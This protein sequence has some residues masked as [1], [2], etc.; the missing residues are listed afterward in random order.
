MR[1]SLIL[2]TAFIAIAGGLIAIGTAHAEDPTILGSP[3]IQVNPLIGNGRIVLTLQNESQKPLA[4][5]LSAGAL[6]QTGGSKISDAAITFGAETDQGPGDL[7]Y[8]FTIP[9]QSTFKVQAI[10]EKE[11]DPGQFEA[12]LKNQAA[13]IGK[14]KVAFFPVNVKIDSATPDKLDLSLVGSVWTAIY[15]KNSD[16]AAYNL[17][18]RLIVGAREIAKNDFSIPPNGTAMLEFTPSIPVDWWNPQ[19]YLARFQDLFKPQPHDGDVLLLY[20]GQPGRTTDLGIPIKKFPVTASLNFFGPA[21]QGVLSYL[22]L[23]AILTLGGVTSLVLSYLLPNRLQ[24]L[25]MKEQLEALARTTANLST[26]VGSKLGVLMRVERSRLYDLL[27]SR[28]TISPDFLNIIAQCKDGV[29]TLT[30]RVTMLQQMDGVK[31]QL[32]EL[33]PLGVPPTQVDQIESSLDKAELILAKSEPTPADLI[34]AQAA[35]TEA[36]DG[37]NTITHPNAQF[38]QELAQRVH[39]AVTEI[40]ANYVARPTFVRVTAAVPGPLAVLQGVAPGAAAVDAAFIIPMDVALAKMRLVR[41]YVLLME[42][43]TDPAMRG[44]L[45]AAEPRLLGYLQLD[46]LEALRSAR[47]LVREMKGDLYPPRLRDALV[48]D[49]KEASIMM[50]PPFAYERQPLKFTLQFHSQAL[51]TA[52]ARDEWACDWSFGDGLEEHGWTVS[53]YFLLSRASVFQQRLAKS[54]TVTATFLDS[55]GHRVVDAAGQPVRITRD[56]RV[57]PS[58]LSRLLGE[59]T[60]TEGLRLAAALLIAVFGLVAGAK[61][62][63]A[64]LDVLPGLVAVFLVG[65]GADTIKNLLTSK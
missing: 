15:L 25:N 53:H 29:A 63:L 17:H 35:I 64:K 62:Q 59:R 20:M 65:F 9:P 61:D 1:I 56:I 51:D 54:F 31:D 39:N 42:G 38:G 13:K 7:S 48:A 60:V 41:D 28:A 18:Y 46:T 32:A 47:L 5:A 8:K 50:D 6:T 23:F 12:D 58:T 45:T 57:T 43:T 36:T 33:I 26:H 55:D 21:S 24:R 11:L 2:H 22:M 19:W 52:A 10:I 3:V 40:A 44:R 37:V 27:T 49:P 14:I 34:A 30:T 16:A 4:V